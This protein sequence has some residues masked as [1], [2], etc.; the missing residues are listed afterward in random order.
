ML[1][2]AS[3][4][5]AQAANGSITRYVAYDPFGPRSEGIVVSKDSKINRL[6]DLKGKRVAVQKGSNSHYLLIKALRSANLTP[7]Q[8][9]ITFLKPSDARAAFERGD[10]DA[11]SIWDPYFAAAESEASAR[12]LHDARGLAPN[13]GYHLSST[14]FIQALQ[15]ATLR[16][17]SESIRTVAQAVSANR[18]RPRHFCAP[19]RALMPQSARKAQTTPQAWCLADHRR[20][21]QQA[22]GCGRYLQ[23]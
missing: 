21:H 6:A 23:T 11:G 2:E 18:R 13:L 8:V 16:K 5:F 12:L 9:T 7:A 17:S 14:P 19:S 10:V 3:P 20:D 15:P 4:I 22:A 1:A